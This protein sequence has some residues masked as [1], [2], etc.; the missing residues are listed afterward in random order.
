[1]I[2]CG[3]WQ[4]LIDWLIICVVNCNYGDLFVFNTLLMIEPRIHFCIYHLQSVFS[5]CCRESLLLVII[6]KEYHSHILSI[7]LDFPI[8]H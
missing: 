2:A 5:V 3:L 1:M 4:W 8:L 6:N 7:I